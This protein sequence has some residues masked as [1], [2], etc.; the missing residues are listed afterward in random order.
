MIFFSIILFVFKDSII[1][2]YKV[3]IL[4]YY[5]K[6]K[7]NYI[8]ITWWYFDKKRSVNSRTKFT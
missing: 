4:S 8:N 7:K 5:F 2:L 3:K 1:L 6:M